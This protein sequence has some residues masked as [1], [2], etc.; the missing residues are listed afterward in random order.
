MPQVWGAILLPPKRAGG[1][2]KNRKLQQHDTHET[3]RVVETIIVC[4]GS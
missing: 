2:K 3:K 1:P 4:L